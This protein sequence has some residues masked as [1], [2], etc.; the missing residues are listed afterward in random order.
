MEALRQQ[1]AALTHRGDSS[2]TMATSKRRR[3]DDSSSSKNPDFDTLCY[4]YTK[5]A[6]SRHAMAKWLAGGPPTGF[7]AASVRA[8]QDLKVADS[9]D[10]ITTEL[11]RLTT[12]YHHSITT[13]VVAHLKTVQTKHIHTIHQSNQT[14]LQKAIANAKQTFN[15]RL[16]KSLP[17]EELEPLFLVDTQPATNT[18]TAMDFSSDNDTSSSDTPPARHPRTSS[19]TLS[20]PPTHPSG[21]L[22]QT[23]ATQVQHTK[24]TN[25]SEF[26]NTP[27]M[28]AAA[29]GR[30]PN[31]IKDIYRGFKQDWTVS[32]AS[33]ANIIILGDSNMAKARRFPGVELYVMPG[34]NLSH[35]CNVLTSLV[36]PPNQKARIF[37]QV[38]INHRDHTN[39]NI[40]H[41]LTNL[42]MEAKKARDRVESLVMVGIATNRKLSEAQLKAINHLNKTAKDML[43][44][45]YI[46]PLSTHQVGLL[47]DR[48]NIHH[49]EATVDLVL[50][51]IIGYDLN[52]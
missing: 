47:S 11:D 37:V 2:T 15:T 40:T 4:A 50:Q 6:S 19:N 10:T 36:V 22:A 39:E 35:V 33:A 52:L 7:I 17:P 12:E 16:S 1:L 28:Y 21:A 23:H 45:N 44:S 46:E 31:G 3:I 8:I 41:Y 34:A 51:S 42:L 48:D 18:E 29:S 32:I 43:G 27:E 49:D 9:D 38:G 25:E 5:L 20:L 13:A 24:P 14:D 30:T 26:A